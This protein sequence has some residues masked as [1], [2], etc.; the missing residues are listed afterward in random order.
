[1]KELLLHLCRYPFNPDDRNR[2]RDLL[3]RVDDWTKAVSLI[4]EH[5]IIALAAYNINEARL[6]E[7]VP[8]HAMVLLKDGRLQSMVRNAWLTQRWKEVNEILIKGGTKHVLLKGM[9]LEYS[10]YGGTGLRQMNDNDILV[11]RDDALKAW[12]LL[13]EQGF[14]SEMIKS[15]LHRKIILDIGKHLPTL[16]KEGYSVE[17]HHRLFNEADAN[18]N[19]PDAIDNAAEI[20]VA[21]TK[22]YTLQDDIHLAYLEKHLQKHMDSGDYQLR[23]YTDME[24]L[25]TG[26]APVMPASFIENPK[27]PANLVQRAH[28]QAI[29][30]DRKIAIETFFELLSQGNSAELTATG[31]SM[32]PALRPGDKALV[33]P[34]KKNKPPVQGSIIVA[35]RDDTLVLHRLVKISKDATGSTVYIT[36]GDSRT[37]D[38]PP[39]QADQL[40]GLADSYMRNNRQRIIIRRIPSEKEYKINRMLLWLWVKLSKVLLLNED[41]LKSCNPPSSTAC[42]RSFIR[43]PKPQAKVVA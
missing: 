13:Q 14:Q 29:M 16:T 25:K 43:Q 7:I 36:R 20:E 1:M 26:S 4:N 42:I 37:E 31:Y 28:C 11:K 18:Q 15:S 6:G 22:A 32:F 35:R 41:R 34:L 33:K 17:I 12:Y 5:G 2:L 23:L 9:A 10:L 24:L 19:L 38:D 39:W 3:S 40:I 30:V 27:Q 21:G 8:D